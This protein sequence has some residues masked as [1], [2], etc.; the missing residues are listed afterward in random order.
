[1]I[2]TR[3]SLIAA[4]SLAAL[5]WPSSAHA[6]SVTIYRMSG[7]GCCHKW[8]E[9][10]AEAGLP[11]TLSDVDDMAAIHSRLGVPDALQGCHAGEIGGYVI[12]GHVPPKD[13]LRLLTD[14][15]AARGLSVA[16]MPQGSPGMETA[17]TDPYQVLLFQTDGT[18][19]VYASYG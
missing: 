8:S 9:L 13:I 3:R 19:K 10:M 18:S 17:T 16:G 5:T 14:K 4:G 12:E 1:M 6:A 15:P 11:V 7:C 2:L